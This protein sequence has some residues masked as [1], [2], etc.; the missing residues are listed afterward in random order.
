MI[1]S[2]KIE[3]CST[4]EY[5]DLKQDYPKPAKHFIPDWYKK[6]KHSVKQN[7][8]KGCMPFLDT[9]TAGYIMSMPQDFIIRHNVYNDEI[10]KNDA[11]QSPS[12]MYHEHEHTGTNL[13]QKTE[14]HGTQQLAGSPL[15]EKNKDLPFHKIT[16]PWLIKTPPGYSCLFVP[17]LNNKDDR[18]E[19]LPG[20]V[21]TDT[22]EKEI[23]F[24]IVINGDKYPTLETIITKG[25]PYVQVI[26]F[27]RDEWKME[28]KVRE[29]EKYKPWELFYR[30]K[31][32]NLYKT[33]F[34]KKKN[35]K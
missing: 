27:K 26:P 8:V 29:E 9:L 7:T 15:V 19:I 23:N 34:W 11:F 28:V 30:L 2:K 22:Y 12:L 5:V 21:D 35:F 33:F 1:F 32:L 6:L 10:K 3:F 4:K 13:A 17:P 16:N 24:P 25:T 20:I 31:L 18:F 14:F